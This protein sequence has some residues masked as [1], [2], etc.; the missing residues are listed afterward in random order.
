MISDDEKLSIVFSIFV[1]LDIVE[2]IWNC[3]QTTQ[4]EILHRMVHKA[5]KS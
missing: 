2:S 5:L 1:T 4:R 3:Y